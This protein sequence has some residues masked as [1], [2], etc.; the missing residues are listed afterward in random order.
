MKEGERLILETILS[1]YHEDRNV[2]L[3][4]NDQK[5]ETFEVLS[6]RELLYSWNLP[7]REGTNIVKMNPESCVFPYMIGEDKDDERCLGIRLADLNYNITK[8]NF[9]FS[10]NWY[11]TSDEEDNIWMYE[12]GTIII[13]SETKSEYVL[14]FVASSFVFDDEVELYL[15][16]KFV[17]K[18]IIKTEGA[19]IFTDLDLEKGNNELVLRTQRECRDMGKYNGNDDI[20]CVTIELSSFVLTKKMM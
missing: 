10:K 3:Y 4:F 6:S 16:G 13:D 1:S 11:E 17:D 19:R 2:T 5:I 8:Q 12:N 15:N 20:R 7:L 18:F 9:S 14:S